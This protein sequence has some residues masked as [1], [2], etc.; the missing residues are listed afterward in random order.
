M[1]KQDRKVRMKIDHR[2]LEMLVAL[3]EAVVGGYKPENE[4]EQLWHDHVCDLYEQISAMCDKEQVNY[5]LTLS[6]STSRAFMQFWKSK[7]FPMQPYPA[8]IL[9][10]IIQTI[11][12]KSKEPLFI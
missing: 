7:P 6:A 9:N 11:D 12:K 10:G 8:T 2:K 5:T 1:R 3:Y 4:Q